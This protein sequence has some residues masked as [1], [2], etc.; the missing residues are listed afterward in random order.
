[1]SPPGNF[2]SLGQSQSEYVLAAALVVIL[3]LPALLGLG[4]NLNTVLD[5]MVPTR[6]SAVAKSMK[7]IAVQEPAEARPGHQ[8]RVPV[9]SLSST[10]KVAL[11]QNLANK[12]QTLGA[13]G[14]TTLLANQLAMLA[15]Q[16]L[17]EGKV[18]TEQ[19]NA[20]MALSNQG[21]RMAMIEG[22]VEEAMQLSR[23]NNTQFNTLSVNVDGKVYSAI[24]AALILG[25]SNV[26][27]ETLAS[28]N[29]LNTHFEGGSELN[30]FLSL[31][32]Q[33]EA[34][35]LMSDPSVKATIDSAAWQI[36]S[37]G[38]LMEGNVWYYSTGVLKEQDVRNSIVK[39]AV[40]LESARICTAGDFKD[41]GVMCSKKE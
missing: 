25:Y 36:V 22:K 6:A 26:G 35:G 41:N 17:M 20:I 4:R 8:T 10:E 24:D 11:S 16:L 38:E 29:L 1:M 13:N 37:V 30:R 40:H 14:T 9:H 15:R 2:H 18:D 7:V 28:E 33:V 32:H 23:G 12:V 27:A 5:T 31:Y 3:V 34:M 39:G 21:H 19:Y